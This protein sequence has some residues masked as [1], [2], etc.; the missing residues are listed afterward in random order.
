[1]A[2]TSTARGERFLAHPQRAVRAGLVLLA[3]V[4][5]MAVLVPAA[6][7]SIDRSWAEA[8]Q[9]HPSSLLRHVALALDWLGKALGIGL[10]LGLIAVVLVLA[11]RWLVIVGFAVA[12]LLTLASTS[13]LKALTHRAR[14]PNGLIHPAGTSFPSGHTSYAGVTLVALVLVFTAPGRRWW[15]WVLAGVG[16]AA[17]AWS[18]TYLQAHWLSDVVAGAMLGVGIALLVFGV[19]QLVAPRLRHL[20]EGYS[21]TTSRARSGT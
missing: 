6:P 16:I 8:M 13:L 17:M 2:S 14:P 12:E 11:R 21:Q 9:D 15:W 1:M 10:S 3:I 19:L 4:A 20:P 5:L 7:L 18:R